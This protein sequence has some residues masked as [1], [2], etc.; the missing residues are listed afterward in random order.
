[1]LFHIW[2]RAVL[3]SPVN[4]GLAMIKKHLHWAVVLCF[5]SAIA[6]GQDAPKPDPRAEA[7]KLMVSSYADAFNK[8]DLEKVAGAWAEDCSYLDRD[9]GE[10]V[11]GR[12]AMRGDLQK[13]FADHPALRL[14][15]TVDRVKSITNNVT[16]VEG[17]TVV[18]GPDS[19]PIAAVFSAVLVETGGKWQIH[20]LEESAVAEPETAYDALKELEWLVGRWVDE[21]ETSRVESTVRWSANNAFLLRSFSMQTED[22]IAGHGTQVIGW[23]PRAR[24]I[25]SWVFNADGSFG[26]GIWSKS[27]GDWLIK[28][29]QTLADGRAASGT[30]VL[31][32][33]NG[34]E[35]QMQ[36]IGH[37]IAGAPQPSSDPVAM[38]RAADEDGK[39]ESESKAATEKAGE[40]DKK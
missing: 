40:V 14:S 6:K 25:R 18:T 29:S 33:V 10:R 37:S 3:F 24:H 8:K 2:V 21:S 34:G 11:E 5:V 28:S 35:I 22:G 7:I 16:S 26:E 19:E 15:A 39:A 1:M 30:Y 12:A 9:S 23:D 38:M 4:Q 17:H 31:T 20:S 36:L 32:Q 27:G 13:G